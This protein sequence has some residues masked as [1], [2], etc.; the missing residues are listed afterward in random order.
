MD[1]HAHLKCGAGAVVA[2]VR[3]GDVNQICSWYVAMCA[4]SY[5][6][7]TG[8]APYELAALYVRV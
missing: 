7:W 6:N 8:R 4:Q 5:E 1:S 3:V 2:Q